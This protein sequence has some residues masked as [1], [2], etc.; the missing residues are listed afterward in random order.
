MA[1]ILA[2]LGK[3]SLEEDEEMDVRQMAAK[4]LLRAIKEDDADALV[5]AFQR[6]QDSAPA[7]EEPDDEENPL[8]ME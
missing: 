5:D 4:D 8:A 1:S 2:L 3:P 6:L 7:D